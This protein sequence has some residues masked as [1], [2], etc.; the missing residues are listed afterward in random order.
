MSDSPDK[1][2]LSTL[3]KTLNR[4]SGSSQPNASPTLESTKSAKR[5]PL[6]T[7]C[8]RCPHA[9]W[10]ATPKHRKC[11]CRVMHSLSYSDEQTGQHNQLI[12]CDG[13]LIDP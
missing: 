9:M 4:G 2:D 3:I 8:Q 11:Y 1:T 13:P 5:P 10:L 12:Q 6:S 7:I